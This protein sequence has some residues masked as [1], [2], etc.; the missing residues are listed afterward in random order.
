MGYIL[1][2]KFLFVVSNV[3]VIVL[4]GESKFLGTSSPTPDIYNE[5]VK[6]KNGSQKLHTPPMARKE[7]TITTHFYEDKP[8]RTEEVREADDWEVSKDKDDEEE[9]QTEKGVEEES[10]KSN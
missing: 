9:L 2:P 5:Y 3:I 7:T 8:V 6:R 4:V 1:C 10:Y